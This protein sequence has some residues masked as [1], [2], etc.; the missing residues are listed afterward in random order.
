MKRLR[1]ILGAGGGVLFVLQQEA[2][3]AD[4]AELMEEKNVGIVAV[5]AGKKLVGV[6]SERDIVRR[7]VRQRRD[8]STTPLEEVMTT[9]LVVSDETEDYRAAIRKLDQANIRHL[10]VI[11][12][13]VVVSMLSV[14][15]LMRVDMERLGEEIKFL[16]AYLY[17]IPPDF[18]QDRGK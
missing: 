17:E 5:L 11:R 3:V 18:R 7:V 16:Q 9:N 8:P 2:T 14:R 12:G 4:A 10:P 13:E 6:V 15:D 1:D